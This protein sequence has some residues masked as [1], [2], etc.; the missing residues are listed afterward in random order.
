MDTH[1]NEL[2]FYSRSLPGDEGKFRHPIR[3]R[4]EASGNVLHEGT[5]DIRGDNMAFQIHKHFP[6]SAVFELDWDLGPYGGRERLTGTA[7]RT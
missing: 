1:G 7:L 3:I 6:E 2:Q 5:L 4:D